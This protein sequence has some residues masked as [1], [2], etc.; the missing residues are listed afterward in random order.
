M[1]SPH[2]NLPKKEQSSHP[3]DGSKE[4]KLHRTGAPGQPNLA[5]QHHCPKPPAHEISSA[6]HCHPH[7][8]KRINTAISTSRGNDDVQ[9]QPKFCAAPRS[10]RASFSTARHGRTTLLL[11][12]PSQPRVCVETMVPGV[13]MALTFSPSFFH[14]FSCPELH[15]WHLPPHRPS[16]RVHWR[17]GCQHSH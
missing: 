10:P 14:P 8:H 2:T 11:Q 16:H 13:W 7:S 5:P 9:E 4:G 1:C 17:K 3:A 12:W 15:R 6:F